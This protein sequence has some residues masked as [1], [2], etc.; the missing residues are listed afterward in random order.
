M[1][2]MLPCCFASCMFNSTYYDHLNSNEPCIQCM[3]E[4]ESDGQL[5][6]YTSILLNR[7]EDGSIGTSVHRKATH[8][9]QYLCFHSTT[10]QPTNELWWGHW[11][12]EQRPSLRQEGSWAVLRKRSWCPRPSRE[13]VTP[14][15][16]YTS[17]PAHSLIGR[18]L[19]TR[20]PLDLWLSPT[21]VDCSN[22]SVGSWTPSHPGYLPS[23]QDTEA[24]ACAPKGPSTRQS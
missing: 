2:Q 7:E 16:S 19:V 3:M 11:C 17:T 13:K 20:W 14:R 4:K 15:V 12:A 1:A 21:S 5:P 6:S 10:L 9:D 8:T 22:P 24:G 23:L 18:L